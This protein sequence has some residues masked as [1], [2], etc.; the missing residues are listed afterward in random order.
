[1]VEPRAFHPS[2]WVVAFALPAGVAL[3]GVGVSSFVGND[4]L[5]ATER[6]GAML[7]GV[8]GLALLL[9]IQLRITVTA[10]EVSVWHLVFVRRIALDDIREVIHHTNV[11]TRSGTPVDRVISVLVK[12]RDGR[13]LSLRPAAS[14]VDA[15]IDAIEDARGARSP[16]AGIRK[17]YR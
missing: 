17:R 6:A 14:Q 4:V 16:V 13:E 12:A 3:V 9:S 10:T 2:L 11:V 8:A 5:D 1:M 15:L 7:A